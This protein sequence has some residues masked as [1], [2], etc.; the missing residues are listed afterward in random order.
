MTL[1]K[2]QILKCF[3]YKPNEVSY[4]IEVS[5]NLRT[6]LQQTLNLS[7]N[8]LFITNPEILKEVKFYEKNS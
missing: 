6:T 2:E 5:D 1:T 3:E 4:T 7:N 8:E